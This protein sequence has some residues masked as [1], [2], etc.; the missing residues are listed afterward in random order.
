[1]K[2]RSPASRDGKLFVA[3]TKRSLFRY[4]FETQGSQGMMRYEEVETFR[5][6]AQL[7]KLRT[8]PPHLLHSWNAEGGYVFDDSK[9]LAFTSENNTVP[10]RL[11]VDMF[12]ELIKL[13]EVRK[14][15]A[16]GRD[17][18]LGFCYGPLAALGFK[19]A[20]SFPPTL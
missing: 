7:W 19:F 2:L 10:P 8:A 11:V 6:S 20:N 1:M 9:I 12:S 4:E 3:R 13:P 15:T 18:C 16:I 17:V 5:K 14:W